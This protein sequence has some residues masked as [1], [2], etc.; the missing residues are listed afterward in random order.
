MMCCLVF[1]LFVLFVFVVLLVVVGMFNKVLVVFDFGKVYV[2]VE[3]GKFDDGVFY[4]MFV[5]G[6]YDFVRNDIVEFV[7]LFGGKILCGGWVDD[8]CI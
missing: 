8:N 5:F 2:V 3:I 7:L 6:C 1:L 4:G